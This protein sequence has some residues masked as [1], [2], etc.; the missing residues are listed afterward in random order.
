[1]DPLCRVRSETMYVLSWRT[2]SALIRVLLWCLFSLLLRNSGNR[3]QNN[4]LVTTETT[5]HSS[6]CIILYAWWR[7]Q[8]A[9][10]WPFV[11]GIHRSSVKSPHKG[12]WGGA[13]M[14]SLICVYINGWLNNRADGDLRRHCAHYDVTVMYPMDPIRTKHITP[15]CIFYSVC[16][17]SLCAR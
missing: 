7:H 17:N 3:H 13:L 16:C 11:R 12:Q 15:M 2:G 8:M 4:P 9:R 5:R 14:L 6:T 10:Y 1:M